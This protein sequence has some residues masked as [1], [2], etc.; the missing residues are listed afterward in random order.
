LLDHIARV[1]KQQCIFNGPKETQRFPKVQLTQNTMYGTSNLCASFKQLDLLSR[2]EK[3][4]GNILARFSG[5]RLYGYCPC[6]GF[7][8]QKSTRW[9][10]VVILMILLLHFIGG[11]LESILNTSHN[12][13]KNLSRN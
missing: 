2:E 12:I 3:R 8:C 6:L 11:L 1:K 7:P 9:R 4:E 13:D 10:G 5:T